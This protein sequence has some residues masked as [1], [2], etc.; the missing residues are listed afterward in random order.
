[1][2]RGAVMPRTFCYTTNSILIVRVQLAK[3]MP[4][5]CSAIILHMVGYLDGD[6]VTPSYD[7]VS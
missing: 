3:T 6:V 2:E 1:M 7:G 4:V 5:Q